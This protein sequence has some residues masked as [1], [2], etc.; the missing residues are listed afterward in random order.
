M[1]VFAHPTVGV[2]LAYVEEPVALRDERRR[3][4]LDGAHGRTGLG[5][6]EG[7]GG[8]VWDR[9]RV[10][11]EPAGMDGD[12]FIDVVVGYSREMWLWV[13]GERQWDEFLTGLAGRVRRRLPTP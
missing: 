4:L 8:L 7:I 12:G 13:M 5:P 11:L 10:V 9:W 2:E 1:S 6:D 3:V